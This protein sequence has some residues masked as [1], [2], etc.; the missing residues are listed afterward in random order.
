MTI[1]PPHV[2][3][4]RLLDCYVGARHGEVPDPPT[5]EHLTDCQ[6]CGAR[7]LA[8]VAFMDGVRAEG[9]IEADAVFTP[10][11]LL[12]QQRHIARRIEQVGRAG[13]VISFPR[14]VAGRA[15]AGVATHTAPRWIAGAAA[16]G[17]FLGVA[18]G[19]YQ[20]EWRTHRPS[21]SQTVPA[22]APPAAR[23]PQPAPD[24][25]PSP[26]MA[27]DDTFLSELEVVLDRPRTD[28]LQFLDVLTPHVREIRDLR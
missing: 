10:E 5:A 4:D 21:S 17:L 12:A 7:Y 3:D 16:A 27:S 25:H 9:E 15:A 18:L 11:R 19:S 26:A 24:P 1:R 6:A 22:P 23:A 8:I 13:R 28:E 20:F 2:S 14:S